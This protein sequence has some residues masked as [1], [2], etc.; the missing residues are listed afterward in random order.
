MNTESNL[1]W[2]LTEPMQDVLAALWLA[3]SVGSF[4][5]YGGKGAVYYHSPIQPEPLRAGCRGHSTYGNFVADEE[6]NVKQYTSQYFA[7]RMINL[8]WVKHGAGEHQFYPAVSDLTDD[9]GNSLVTAYGLARPDGEWSLL[10]INKDP[11]N[12]HSVHIQFADQVAKSSRHF[13]GKISVTTFG[14][15]QYVWHPDGAKSHAE[16]DGPP[17]VASVDA[18]A[19]TEFA[20]AR[21][22]V[23]VLRGKIR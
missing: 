14:A 15:E 21:A 1:S 17:A 10:V 12:A 11:A 20:L 2:E 9:A 4:L 19:E 3:D 22:S 13:E 18:K 8:E 5:E 6:L 16:P 23:T 7:S